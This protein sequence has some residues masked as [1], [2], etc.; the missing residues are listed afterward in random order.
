MIFED[1]A[2]LPF[3]Q[4][5]LYSQE[6]AAFLLSLSDSSV[7]RLREDNELP[8]V[9]VRGRVLYRKND[10]KSWVENLPIERIEKDGT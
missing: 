2:N 9:R 6:E 10:L 3:D 4:K 1:E 5:L 8:A 7:K